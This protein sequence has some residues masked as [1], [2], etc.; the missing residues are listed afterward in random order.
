MRR[1][2]VHERFYL[3]PMIQPS[4]FNA[5]KSTENSGPNSGRLSE[6]CC[7]TL[8]CLAPFFLDRSLLRGVVGIDRSADSHAKS[9]PAR[10]VTIAR[11]T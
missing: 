2:A 5:R 10:R 6:F 8:D 11:R 1:T 3:T 4:D 9:P 7:A